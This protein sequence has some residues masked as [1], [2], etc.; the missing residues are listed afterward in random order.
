MLVLAY[1]G[2]QLLGVILFALFFFAAFMLLVAYFSGAVVHK[3]TGQSRKNSFAV[4]CLVAVAWLFWT[5][6]PQP[7][8]P[9]AKLSGL[10]IAPA[11]AV[12]PAG[13]TKTFK[14]YA[15]YGESPRKRQPDGH[16]QW[17][18]NSP[19]VTVSAE[20]VATGVSPG[21]AV[22]T[23]KLLDQQASAKVTVSTV[24]LVSLEVVPWENRLRLGEECSY[25]AFGNWSDGSRTDLTKA[26]TFASSDTKVA[27]IESSTGEVLTLSKGK[28]DIVAS[29]RGLK[30]TSVLTVRK[31]G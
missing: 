6:Q 29:Y 22:I 14:V 21:D 2:G 31:R 3:V 9:A 18:S 10:E 13:V 20:G 4:G 1:T 11:T 24:K 30:D 17:L 16:V 5:C 19:N 12:F 25:Q 27:T 7:P 26:V 28:T 23:V 8:P 15:R